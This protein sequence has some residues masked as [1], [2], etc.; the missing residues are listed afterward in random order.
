MP[1]SGTA[2]AAPIE[3]R[4]VVPVSFAEPSWAKELVHPRIAACLRRY[5]DQLATFRRPRT[6]VMARSTLVSLF[7]WL[8]DAYPEVTS[9]AALGRPHIEDWKSYRSNQVHAGHPLSKA[10]SRIEFSLLSSFLYY[11]A[12][13]AWE[14]APEGSLILKY[15]F[16]THDDRHPRFLGDDEVSALL[17]AAKES[18]YLF[19][20]VSVVTLLFTGMRVGEFVRL[21]TD[22]V[23]RIGSAEWMRLP[24][25]KLH[26]DRF[27]PIH[28]EV[29]QVLDE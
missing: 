9:V 2:L 10:T 3:G 25:G 8:Q 26:N 1:A 12:A 4:R 23:L 13:W 27:I 28:A 7:T 17:K 16:P 11:L 14:D 6:V 20:K 29:R 22:S 15:D 5:V 18:S 19:G 24:I 21:R